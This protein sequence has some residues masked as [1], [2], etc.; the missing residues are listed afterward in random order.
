MDEQPNDGAGGRP[1]FLSG[2]TGMIGGVTALVVALG[3]LA[4]ATR[5]LWRS[6]PKAHL[7]SADEA[8]VKGSVDRQPAVSQPAQSPDSFTVDGGEGGTLTKIDKTW[9]WTTADLSRYEYEEYSNDGTT[10]VAVLRQEPPENDFYLRWPNAGG[11]ALQSEDNR[12]TWGNPIKLTPKK[13]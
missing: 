10:T 1:K 11:A 3:G 8:G 2:T 4:T 9:L 12:K 13:S 6:E 7:A 5:D